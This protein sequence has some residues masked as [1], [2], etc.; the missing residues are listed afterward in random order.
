VVSWTVQNITNFVSAFTVPYLL[1][2]GYANLKSKVGFIYG[3]IGMC[4]IVW[5][6][7]FYPELKQRSLEEI[8]E[9]MRQDVPARRTKCEI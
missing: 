5:A 8:D 3:S 1:N 9:M 6:F 2:P 4:G 7:F